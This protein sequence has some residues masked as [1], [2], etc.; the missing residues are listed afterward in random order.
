M[1]DFALLAVVI[2]A[3][4]VVL[5]VVIR[6][7]VRDGVLDARARD[8]AELAQRNLDSARRDS[9]ATAASVEEVDDRGE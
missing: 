2:V 5:Y 9:R 4:V 6:T 3:G 7:G 8:D 1:S